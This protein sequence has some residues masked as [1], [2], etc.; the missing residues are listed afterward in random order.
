[1]RK[2]ITTNKNTLAKKKHGWRP[3]KK[4]RD[5][6]KIAVRPDSGST[7]EVWFREAGLQRQLWDR[8]MKNPTFA[9]WW[10]AGFERGMM[11]GES[12]LDKIGMERANDKLDKNAFEYWK[13]LQ[14]KYSKRLEKRE[15]QNVAP[16]FQFNI[17]RPGQQL[18]EGEERIEVDGEVV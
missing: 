8:W 11:E 3:N 13:F 4:M 9:L 5:V 12:Y 16:V 15:A 1:M 7:K 10:N 6:L 18:E 2:L 14:E 17:P